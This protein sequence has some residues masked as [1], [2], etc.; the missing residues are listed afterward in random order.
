MTKID[1]YE[2]IRQKLNTVKGFGAPKHKKILEFLK[3]IWNDEEVRLLNN[4][5]GVGKFV[6]AGK[7]AEKA[8]MEESRVK[9]MLDG[10]A[11]KG[12]IVQF[13]GQ[14]GLIPF[15]PGILELYYLKLGDT[16]E[17]HKKAAKLL[18]EVID[19][20]IP[21]M[22]LKSKKGLLTP[23]LPFEAKE[24]LILIDKKINNESQVLP[25]ELV[26]ELINKNDYF[27]ALPC[28]CRL[29]G[30]Y[31]DE[32]CELTKADESGCLACGMAAQALVAM[33]IGKKITKEEAIAHIKGAAKKGLIH[34]GAN[35]SG[36][37]S[38]ML[39]CNCCP[40]HCG[41]LSPTVKHGVPA[42][43]T[44]SN[45]RPVINQELCKKCETCIKKCP[46]DA[47]FHKWPIKTDS[48]D[49]EIVSFQDKCMGCGVCAVNCPENAILMEKVLF[50]VPPAE[51]GLGMDFLGQQ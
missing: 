18:R 41:L 15:V 7:V 34:N 24:K 33:G 49:E 14:Y 13:G 2:S 23:K 8:G 12:T 20:V 46:M 28:Q 6:A 43:V 47:L 27:V 44:A 22:T 31:A 42:G 17:N 19:K 36:P 26:E 51:S 29:I 25:H 4:F 1:Y 11:A 39:I 35:S 30:E 16:E 21:G 9:E 5:K 45:Y 3:I 50:D 37:Q 10:M 32:P 40:C 38:Y 48:S